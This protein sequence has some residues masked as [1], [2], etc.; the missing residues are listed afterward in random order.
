MQTLRANDFELALLDGWSDHSQI[1]LVAPE[2]PIFTPNLQI[3][4]EPLPTGVTLE[5]FFRQQRAELATLDGFSLIEHGERT[6]AGR[7]ALHHTYA[8]T[9]PNNPDTRVQQRQVVVVRDETLFTIT[10]SALEQDWELVEASFEQ[11]LAGFTFR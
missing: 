8:W 6:L 5:A 3:H 4:R 10:C 2:R 11:S 9:M 1:V 7:A